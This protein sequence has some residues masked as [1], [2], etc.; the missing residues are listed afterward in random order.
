MTFSTGDF[1]PDSFTIASRNMAC[2]SF[3]V[4]LLNLEGSRSQGISVLYGYLRRDVVK[5]IHLPE[6][7]AYRSFKA[8]VENSNERPLFSHP[9]WMVGIVLIFAVL[10]ILGGF[11][12]PIW[13]LLGLPCILALVL[14]I[15]VRIVTRYRNEK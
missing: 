2:P 13:F 8:M 12:D 11:S 5:Q 10:S 15:Y 4:I 3:Q 9:P 6:S 1:F 7:P 14:F